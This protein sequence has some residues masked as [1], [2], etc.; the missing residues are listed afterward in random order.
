MRLVADTSALVSIAATSDA[1]RTV[2]PLLF[3]GYNVAVPGQVIDELA[4]VAR[5]E[6]DHARAAQA[7]LDRR[8]RIAVYEIELDPE[9]PLDAGENAAVQLTE[10][11]GADYFYCDEYNRLALIHASLSEPQLVT[12]PRI[13]KALVVHGDLAQSD[14]KTILDGISKVRSWGENAYVQQAEHLFD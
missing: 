2:L 1:R 12:T 10:E 13:L 7:I 8:E 6:D 9:F 3:E 14:A 4:D 5:Y 11:V